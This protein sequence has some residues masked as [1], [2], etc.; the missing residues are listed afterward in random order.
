ME[1]RVKIGYPCLNRSLGVRTEEKFRLASY[2]ESRFVETVTGNL[3][4]LARVLEWNAAQGLDFFRISSDTIPFASHPVCCVDWVSR[5][6]DRLEKIG[7]AI[8]REKTRISMHPDQF[9]LLN[10]PREEVTANSVAELEYHARFLDALG[11][12][13]DAKIQIHV[14]GVYGDKSAAVESFVRRYRK[15]PAG[16][17]ER[18]VIENDDR[19]FSLR[20]CLDIHSATGVPVLFDYFH[21]ECLNG[22][23]SAPAAIGSAAQTWKKKDGAPMVDYSSQQP[24]DRKGRHADHLDEKH[25]ARFLKDSRETEIDVM[26]EIKDKEPSALSALALARKSGRAA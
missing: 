24:G 25:F 5:F 11:L 4:G 6:R 26:L 12:E 19:L 14:G 20:D 3:D 17:R 23:E 7:A 16:I 1:V 9:V 18:L 15:L 8:R 13:A 22:G 21:H 10:S 2:S